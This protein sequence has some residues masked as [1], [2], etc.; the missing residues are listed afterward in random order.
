MELGECLFCE[1][2]FKLGDR[3]VV[4]GNGVARPPRLSWVHTDCIAAEVLGPN[5]RERYQSKITEGGEE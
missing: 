5:W 1:T 4:I 3:G 2:P